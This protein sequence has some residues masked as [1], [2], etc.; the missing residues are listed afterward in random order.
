VQVELTARAHETLEPAVRRVRNTMAEL[1]GFVDVEDSRPLPGVE[2][3]LKV[4]RERAARFG[5]DV[6]LLGQA[7]RLI[8]NGIQLG[9]YRPDDADEEVDI[10]IRYPRDERNLDRLTGLRVPTR[11]GLVPISNFVTFEPQPRTGTLN[12][13]DG[14]RVM[15]VAAD[16]GPDRLVSEQVN[17]LRQ[18][19][20]GADLPDSVQV[21]FKGESEDQQAAASFLSKAFMAA[22]LLMLAVL[23]TQFNNFY[24]A[25]IIL[26]A[27]VFATAGVLLGLLATGR[28]FGIVM[29]GVGVIALAGIVVNNNIVLIDTYNQHLRAG[30][31]KRAAILKTAMQRR[32]PVLLTSITTILGLLPMVLKLNVDLVKGDIAY[33]APSTQWWTELSTSIAGGLLFA[34]LLTLFL[35]PCFLML[36]RRKADS[37]G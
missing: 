21:R 35:T 29:S 12:R 32:R 27:I 30:M 16:V 31:A 19:L 8:T 18:A 24:Q 15:T 33:G 36:G 6:T 28:P 17:R 13:V 2:W 14:R 5:A 25:F 7:V 4:D 37:A 23:V 20:A 34:T 3:A 22:V 26:S 1:G 11:T 9:E 10:R